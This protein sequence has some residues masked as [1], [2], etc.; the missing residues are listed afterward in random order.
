MVSSMESFSELV[1][2]KPSM[3]K[4]SR[5]GG[6]GGTAGGGLVTN[7]LRLLAKLLVSKRTSPRGLLNIKSSNG[8]G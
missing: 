6:G 4:N 3:S 2:L 5:M 7:L 1:T 8:G